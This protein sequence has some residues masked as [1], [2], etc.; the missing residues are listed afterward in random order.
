MALL[1]NSTKSWIWIKDNQR[2]C[3]DVLIIREDED[4]IIK[5]ALYGQ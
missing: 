3:K 4:G 5:I 2:E 1:L